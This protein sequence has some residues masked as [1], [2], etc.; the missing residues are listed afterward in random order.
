MSQRIG[1]SE[2]VFAEFRADLT[3][4]TRNTP[5]ALAA[6]LR[7]KRILVKV[8]KSVADGVREIIVSVLSDIANKQIMGD[9]AG[10]LI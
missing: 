4:L 6:S 5:K 2:R 8:G 1:R 3:E 7:F 10:L 9:S